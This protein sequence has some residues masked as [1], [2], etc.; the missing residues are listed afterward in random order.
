MRLDLTST[1]SK[2]V[3]DQQFKNYK[4]L[5]ATLQIK[6][7]TGE[8]KQLQL[9]EISRFV[10]LKKQGHRFTV[11]E[12]Y[13]IPKEK[14]KK[15]NRN[16]YKEHIE[17]LMLQSL[18]ELTG[19]YD[20]SITVIYNFRSLAY[21][22]SMINKNFKF[23]QN[24]SWLEENNLTQEQYESFYHAAKQ[25]LKS[26]IQTALRSL[27]RNYDIGFTKEYLLT[28]PSHSHRSGLLTQTEK[29]WY[30]EAY[31]AVINEFNP[32]PIKYFGTPPWNIV[33]YTS[34]RDILLRNKVK[35]FYSK[36]NAMIE[37]TFGTYS[38][39]SEVYRIFTT[40]GF[41]DGAKRNVSDPDKVSEE[42][43]ALNRNLCNEMRNHLFLPSAFNIIVHFIRS[44]TCC[45]RFFCTY[46]QT[47]SGDR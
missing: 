17:Y 24:D 1:V 8:A 7:T 10:H 28:T 37:D 35:E 15:D 21:N 11:K 6:P 42:S 39:I 44:R 22:L 32:P 33:T 29:E 27:E 40:S 9:E 45:S 46:C 3:V 43:I 14:V 16:K 34:F 47:H 23:H 36:L 31:Q 30:R 41:M 4:E 20:E 12:I 13:P 26:Y 38:K 2:L 5:C 25:R 19:D 18:Y